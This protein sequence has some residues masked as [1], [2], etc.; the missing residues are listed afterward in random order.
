MIRIE[1]Q[2]PVNLV[3]EEREL[4][5]PHLVHEIPEPSL[6]VYRAVRATGM[7][8][9]I[10]GW[11]LLPESFPDTLESQEWSWESKKYNQP[12][13]KWKTI[14]R[15]HLPGRIRAMDGPALWFTDTWSLSYFF[16]LSETLARLEFI[17]DRVE[18]GWPIVI[19]DHYLV[20]DFVKTT[21]E[22]FGVSNLVPV[23]LSH[24]QVVR[25]LHIPTRTAGIHHFNPELIKRVGE[26]FRATDLPA[27]EGVGNKLH[28]SRRKA[29]MRKFINNDAV[30]AVFDAFGYSTV[31]MED[32]SFREQVGMLTRAR[33]L[34]SI[35]GAGLTNMLMMPPGSAVFEM[36][37]QGEFNSSFFNLAS[38]CG[39]PYYYQSCQPEQ[40]DVIEQKNNFIADID[41]LKRNLE[42]IEKSL[43]I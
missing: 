17:R 3:E 1:R 2:L 11:S 39:H 41:V 14:M 28:I 27:P 33:A 25:E 20:V 42:R 23:P 4:F 38:A 9:L 35:H 34:A 13:T 8:I 29:R 37:M 22:L 26:R 6:K 10:K 32:Y 30:D 16:W 36:R 12:A 7:G 21:L 43:Q 40:P 18:A 31:C 5:E 24:C 15:S 19:P